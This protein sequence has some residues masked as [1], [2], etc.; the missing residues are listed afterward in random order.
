MYIIVDGIF[1]TGGIKLISDWIYQNKER[2][3]FFLLLVSPIL[4]VLLY[5]FSFGRTVLYT[6]EWA[7]VPTIDH[8]FNGNLTFG[9]FF[10]QH[11]EHRMVFPILTILILA[12]MTGFNTVSEMYF[13]WIIF[14]VIFILILFLCFQYF[15]KSVQTLFLFVPVAWLLGSLRQ[16]ENFLFGFQINY[17]LCVLGFVLAFILLDRSN[18]FG[19]PFLGA[20]G[21]AIVT[22]F[23]L[24][25]GLLVW[26]VG[27][28]QILLQG[29]GKKLLLPWVICAVLVN[30]LYFLDWKRSENL[31]AM[32][33][34]I[35]DPSTAVKYFIAF[36]GSPLSPG[37]WG[38]IIITYSFLV[39][40][41]VLILTI[42]GV[43]LT[44]KYHLLK[45]N[46]PWMSL[47]LF[48][49]GTALITTIG[50]SGFGIVQALSSRYVTLTIPG[51]IGLYFLY[52]TL[53]RH[54]RSHL[55]FTGWII[56]GITCLILIGVLFGAME[57]LT[58]G[59]K[60]A[61]DRDKMTCTLINYHSASDDD[62]SALYPNPDFIRKN[63]GVLERWRFNVFS[64]TDI[65]QRNASCTT[66]ITYPDLYIRLF[67][68][69]EQL[70]HLIS[71]QTTECTRNC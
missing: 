30:S 45:E 13:I 32:S 57:G 20:L 22:S 48:S 2:V 47:L 1:L 12:L 21:G 54:K 14:I 16:W 66:A 11:N 37:P 5:I 24:S 18:K 64:D 56:K 6:D 59:M 71:G 36:L 67:G 53:F 63:A 7:I 10:A 25:N 35:D 43:A 39:G 38:N 70:N 40:I 34:F 65:S 46:S 41:F 42:A 17:F 58:M 69:K 9:D 68:Y 51:I 62:L 52:V 33:F 44:V 4:I 15:G 8:F 29:K 55:P 31:P 19:L 26:P 23:S 49:M 50:R 60:I 61:S 27:I 28:I 3:L